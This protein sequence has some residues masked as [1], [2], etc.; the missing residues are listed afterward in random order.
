MI[1]NFTRLKVLFVLLLAGFSRLNAQDKCNTVF[2]QIY[3]G[4]GE[5]EAY[6][7][8]STSDRSMVVAGRSTSGSAGGY[9]GFL[10]K[11]DNAGAVIWT[12]VIGGTGDDELLNVKQTADNGFIA[13]GK[14]CSSGNPQGSIWIV[15]TDA[16]GVLLWSRYFSTGALESA[17]GKDII[18][19]AGGGYAVAANINDSTQQGD[20]LVIKTDALG[21]AQWTRRFDKGNDDGFNNLL[22]N[23]GAIIV[24]GYATQDLRDGILMELDIS[25]G[26]VR[27][28]QQFVRHA[29]WNEEALSVA[30]IPGGIAWALKVYK[31][32]PENDDTPLELMAIKTNNAGINYFVRRTMVGTSS[33]RRATQLAV[34]PTLDSGFAYAY[35]DI[36]RW[37]MASLGK[38][39][40]PGTKEWTRTYTDYYSDQFFYGL[41][42]TGSQGYVC[43]GRINNGATNLVNKVFLVKTDIMGMTG[44]CSPYAWGGDEGGKDNIQGNSFT[45]DNSQNVTLSDN[46]FSPAMNNAPFTMTSICKG[47]YCDPDPPV[48]NGNDCASS[49]F[50]EVKENYNIDQNDVVRTADG[51]VVTIGSRI[52]YWTDRAQLIKIKPNGVVRWTR[53]LNSRALLEGRTVFSRI[54]STSDNKLLVTGYQTEIIDHSVYTYGL[55]YKLDYN[56]NVIWSRR[57]GSEMKIKDVS[58]TEDGGFVMSANGTWGE[59]WLIKL[60]AG[61]NVVW[62]YDFPS[63][64]LVFRSMLY[65]KGVVYLGMD[66]SNM[67]AKGMEVCKIDTRT[68]QLLWSKQY[69]QGNEELTM[70]G[71][72]KM[73]D[74]L[75][76][77][78]G[79]MTDV[80]LFNYNFSFS[81]LRLNES[82]GEQQSAFRINVPNM[83]TSQDYVWLDDRTPSFFVKTA[84]SALAFVHECVA[85]KDTTIQI[86][87][88]SGKGKIVWSRRYP[89]LKHHAIYGVKRDGYGFLIAGVRYGR[90]Q[91][92]DATRSGF[93]MRANNEGLVERGSGGNCASEPVA[94]VVAPVTFTEQSP[95]LNSNL[96][97]GQAAVTPI[98]LELFRSPTLTY[99]SCSTPSLCSTI[100]ISGDADRCGLEQ[101]AVFKALRNA[102]CNTPVIWEVD[103]TF[104]TVIDTTGGE[105]KIKFR[106]YGRTRITAL[107]DAG[108]KLV[109]ASLD[110]NVD[111]SVA[112]F[113][114]G[115]DAVL[116]KGNVY[117]LDAGEGF[118]KYLWQDGSSDQVYSV[119]MPGTYVVTV[120]DKC[121]Q[122]A[123]DQVEISAAP[124]YPFSLGPDITKCEETTVTLALPAGFSNYSWNTDFNLEEQDGQ[125]KLFPD[126][127]TA[128]IL[129]AEKGPGC[130]LRDTV[131][132][133]IIL[134]DIMNLGTDQS[135]CEGDSLKL[136]IPAGFSDPVWSTGQTAM[137]IFVRAEGSYSASAKDDSRCLSRD[138]VNLQSPLTRPVVSLPREEYICID[139]KRIIDAG[140]TGL[141]YL[142]NTGATANFIEVD[143]PGTWWVT[144]TGANGC[145]TTD[146]AFF[147]KQAPAPAAFLPVDTHIC[148]LGGGIRL[149][150]DQ[151]YLSYKWSTGAET[152]ELAVNTP[153]LYWLEVTDEGGCHGRDSVN[154][155]MKDCARGVYI[156]NAFSPNHDGK[157][158]VLRPVVMG[159]VNNYVF[160]VFD[161]WGTT[162]FQSR[163]LQKGWDGTVKGNQA[164]NGVYVWICTYQLQGED[165]KTDK[166]TV[167]LIR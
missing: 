104:A 36:T 71:I 4:S 63:G 18:E 152:R 99:P 6:A 139:T 112:G 79:L 103:T 83:S 53:Q 149:F 74:T 12:R 161:R 67:Y 54:I 94:A 70:Q 138:T 109:R 145:K 45:W 76:I 166:G 16:N 127:D 60:D 132:V 122:T 66:Y 31:P 102:G 43:A 142:W 7:V 110:V 57:V 137:E 5:E 11:L 167:L 113:D 28:V 153:G 147:K 125:V 165:Q 155:E 121:G 64:G 106:R 30:K 116:C 129:T 14:T 96:G 69:T 157:H 89:N 13:I 17:K 131:L 86:V 133:K 87:K 25:D 39:D 2:Q 97:P 130:V 51:D 144:V 47:D 61:G 90:N 22:E 85:N 123:I 150:A 163:E 114:L 77:G 59:S 98:P 56:G 134:P 15:K 101:V 9:D 156:P 68:G 65:E 62:K 10:L 119:T 108:C 82:N 111:R 41:D 40:E 46:P 100:S 148:R 75:F 73:G 143:E 50:T 141:S 20:G 19:L 26:A 52:Y 158:D 37:G 27:Q 91:L 151:S 93:V 140:N 107:L 49:F 88:F 21:M 24:A 23:N 34:K 117:K 160:T 146:T 33:G 124:D 38:M 120:S 1:I 84:D 159:L 58:E 135:I 32:D 95:L 80:S 162:V 44:S 126:Q 72:Q 115:A 8:I 81:V 29:G 118:D 42:L 35:H 136:T 78:A 105:L 48:D 3:G 55:A 92:N 128:Y 154:V 164:V